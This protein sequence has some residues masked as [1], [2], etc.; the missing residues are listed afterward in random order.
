MISKQTID[1]IFS[2]IRVEEIVGEYVQLKRAGSNF[3]GLSPFH[4]EKSPSFV[5]SA[6]KQ[7]W[8]DFST[9][10]GGT[11]ISFLMEIENLPILKHFVTRQ[12]NT[13]LKLKK[14][15][16]IFPKKQKMH[17]RKEIYCIKF[18]KLPTIFSRIFFGKWKRGDQSVFLILKNVNFEMI[19]LKNSTRIFS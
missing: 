19:S 11:A 13:E 9:G 7:I 18:M 12:K 4:D 1:K 2:T 8:K 15:R 16:K 6:S 17:S 10:K 14:I 3:K 5:V